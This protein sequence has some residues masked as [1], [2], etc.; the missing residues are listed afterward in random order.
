MLSIAYR[1]T[2]E[3]FVSSGILTCCQ[4]H[5]SPQNDPSGRKDI[6]IQHQSIELHWCMT[7]GHGFVLNNNNKKKQQQLWNQ[8]LW[9][10]NGRQMS[11]E[12]LTFIFFTDQPTIILE[13]ERKKKSAFNFFYFFYRILYHLS[14]PQSCEVIMAVNLNDSPVMTEVTMLWSA[15]RKQVDQQPQRPPQQTAEKT[16]ADTVTRP[17]TVTQPARNHRSCQ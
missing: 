7:A 12:F 3:R 14:A 2:S 9:F 6:H 16:F 1:V 4:L 10:R 15:A 8:K 17:K 5:R 13:M 11:T